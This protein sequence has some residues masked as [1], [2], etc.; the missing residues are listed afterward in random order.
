MRIAV[1]SSDGKHID[2]R[3]GDAEFIYVYRIYKG[4]LIF[5]DRRKT[6]IFFDRKGKYRMHGTKFEKVY[7]SIKDCSILVT[8]WIGANQAQRFKLFGIEVEQYEGEIEDLL[9][10]MNPQISMAS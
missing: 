5:V 2:R 10:T 1:T 4:K 7:D 9:V 6:Q 3:Y 8:K